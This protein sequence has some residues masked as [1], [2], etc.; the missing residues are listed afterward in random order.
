M[1][2]VSRRCCGAGTVAHYASATSPSFSTTHL[3]R[4]SNGAHARAHTHTTPLIPCPH[5]QAQHVVICVL[6]WRDDGMR[7]GERFD[8]WVPLP[9][10]HDPKK[11]AENRVG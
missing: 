4:Y 8:R 9:Y 7:E 6:S 5:T 10:V 2:S 3:A 1:S 11:A